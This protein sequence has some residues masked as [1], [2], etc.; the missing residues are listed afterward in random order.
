MDSYSIHNEATIY[1]IIMIPRLSFFR[2]IGQNGITDPA[3]PQ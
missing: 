3:N 1:T 2:A